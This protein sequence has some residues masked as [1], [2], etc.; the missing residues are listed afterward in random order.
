MSLISEYE[1]S[2]KEVWAN[3]F[4]NNEEDW[5]ALLCEFTLQLFS[6]W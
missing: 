4:Q 1:V 2:N 3:G 5:I 6:A